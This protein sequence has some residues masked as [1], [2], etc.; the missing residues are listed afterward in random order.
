M[1]S[2]SCFSAEANIRRRKWFWYIP[3]TGTEVRLDFVNEHIYFISRIVTQYMNCL[4]W[5]IPRLCSLK[6]KKWVQHSRVHWMVNRFSFLHGMA[7]KM[8]PICSALNLQSFPRRIEITDAVDAGTFSHMQCLIPLYWYG[9]VWFVRVRA[10]QS[11][12]DVKWGSLCLVRGTTRTWS[13]C[14]DSR[15]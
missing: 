3:G 5:T 1:Y 4:T 8:G 9:A 14:S 10:Q 15:K 12:L 13:D 11:L 2:I 7:Y 6:K